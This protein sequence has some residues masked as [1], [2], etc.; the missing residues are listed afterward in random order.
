MVSAGRLVAILAVMALVACGTVEQNSWTFG[1]AR[2][3]A[4]EIGRLIH[5]SHGGS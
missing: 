2:E 3:D 5:A 1:V 4:M